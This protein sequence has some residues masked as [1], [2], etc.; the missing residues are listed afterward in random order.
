[1]SGAARVAPPAGGGPVP[2]LA[3]A[4]VP[5][6]GHAKG[7]C[8]PARALSHRGC[9]AGPV[10]LVQAARQCRP[11]VSIPRADEDNLGGGVTAITHTPDGDDARTAPQLFPQPSDMNVDGARVVAPRALVPHGPEQLVPG[12]GPVRRAQQVLQQ[13]ELLVREGDGPAVDGDLARRRSTMTSCRGE[14]RRG[15]ATRNGPGSAAASCS[16]TRA[17]SCPCGPC[18][19]RVRAECVVAPGASSATTLATARARSTSRARPAGPT[20]GSSPT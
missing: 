13:R 11:S 9:T 6:L 12:H 17:T 3:R 19:P 15:R 18:P 10:N 4:A 2:D 1:M 5:H 14:A 20:P 8:P 16:R 7:P